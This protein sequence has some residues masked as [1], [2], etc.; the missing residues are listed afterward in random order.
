MV[1]VAAAAQPCA[2]VARCGAARPK[3]RLPRSLPVAGAIAAAR[4]AA[5]N[6][7]EP[8]EGFVV[9]NTKQAIFDNDDDDVLH[10]AQLR[11][12]CSLL[13]CPAVAAAAAAARDGALPQVP[14]PAPLCATAGAAAREREKG[15]P[16]G[17]PQGASLSAAGTWKG[18]AAA[19]LL[20]C[21]AVRQP[22]EPNGQVRRQTEDVKSPSKDERI[23]ARAWLLP[24]RPPPSPRRWRCL[25]T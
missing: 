19:L 5:A 6:A 22:Q 16:V 9:D 15:A 25:S 13:C 24:L 14:C 23:L 17:S 20:P 10:R 2:C 1:V 21:S 8:L 18:G 11:A 12:L 3:A 7:P 4:H